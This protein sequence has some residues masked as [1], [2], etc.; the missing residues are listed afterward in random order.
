MWMNQK[1]FPF[2]QERTM[3]LIVCIGLT[4]QLVRNANSWTPPQVLN[5]RLV[6]GASNLCPA[7]DSDVGSSHW[8][9]PVKG[10]E[11][12]GLGVQ[13]DRGRSMTSFKQSEGPQ[14]GESFFIRQ[15]ANSFCSQQRYLQCPCLG[16]YL[17][18]LGCPNMTVSCPL[19]IWGQCYLGIRLFLNLERPT[20]AE[21]SSHL[22][23]CI[24]KP[25]RWV[26]F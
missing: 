4:W 9:G 23:K 13:G 16:D 17:G 6:D 22:N 25:I 3:A 2:S 24:K 20:W 14:E 15:N 5:Q 11:V 18:A 1:Q 8:E 19:Y 12:S 21:F 26:H 10:K 7:G